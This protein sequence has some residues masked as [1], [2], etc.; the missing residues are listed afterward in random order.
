VSVDRYD[1]YVS[2]K[3]VGQRISLRMVAAEQVFVIEHAGREVKRVAI[4]G[5]RRSGPIPFAEWVQHLQQEAI[6]ERR[7]QRKQTQRSDGLERGRI[8]VGTLTAAMQQ[9]GEPLLGSGSQQAA[10]RPTRPA[11]E[12]V[13]ASGSQQVAPRPTPPPRDDDMPGDDDG[14]PF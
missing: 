14:I 10:P 2:Q 5:L 11:D 4:K 7:Q 3:L 13:R 9:Q 1:Y 8:W 6:S 12:P